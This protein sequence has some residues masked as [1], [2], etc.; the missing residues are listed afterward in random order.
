MVSF[1]RSIINK[2]DI[3]LTRAL[4]GSLISVD[5]LSCLVVD[6]SIFNTGVINAGKYLCNKMNLDENMKYINS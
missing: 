1:N 3:N 6:Y 4:T 5:V 2:K